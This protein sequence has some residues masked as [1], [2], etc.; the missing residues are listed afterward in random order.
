MLAIVLRYEN[1]IFLNILKLICGMLCIYLMFRLTSNN[2]VN[3]FINKIASNSFGIYLLHSPLVYITYSK[4]NNGNPVIV[5]LIN[6]FVF[7]TLSYLLTSII[8]Y[9]KLNFII[10][11]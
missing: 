4:L 2:K 11:E 8:R 10:G 3:K 9:L 6:F 1:F 7:G 5:I